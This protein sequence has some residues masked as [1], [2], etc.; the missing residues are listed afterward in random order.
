MQL[1]F[2]F[3][4]LFYSST[5]SFSYLYYK[6]SIILPRHY[7]YMFTMLDHSRLS[8]HLIS[9]SSGSSGSINHNNSDLETDGFF[10]SLRRAGGPYLCSLPVITTPI[11]SSGYRHLDSLKRDMPKIFLGTYQ[12]IKDEGVTYSSIG[13]EGRLSRVDPE[14]RPI[15]TLVITAR[16]VSSVDAL[17]DWR[18]VTRKVYRFLASHFP[19]IAVE[20]IDEEE[21]FPARCSPVLKSDTIF[22]KWELIAS[23]ILEHFDISNWTSLQCW[24]YGKA[25]DPHNNPVTIIVTV[26]STA[27]D[28]FTAE[29]QSIQRIL[30]SFNEHHVSVVFVEDRF[31]HSK[32]YHEP[33]LPEKAL[34]Q[35]ALSG[36]GLGFHDSTAGPSTFAGMVE[37]LFDSE[38]EWKPYGLTCLNTNHRQELNKIP[39]ASNGMTESS[40]TN[41]CITDC[42][43]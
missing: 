12:I 41:F 29:N 16:R 10:R 21:I 43:L 26:T 2:T 18:E 35:K 28:K 14:W 6:C 22:P 30:S 20:L 25:R 24:R 34:S 11:S 37:L 23:N 7:H 8:A 38:K 39:G 27:K 5:L 1:H 9:H 15:P 33:P 31:K 3:F 19:G 13:F 32:P 36:V 4:L 42:F 17:T 40:I